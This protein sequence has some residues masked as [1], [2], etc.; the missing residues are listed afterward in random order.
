MVRLREYETA[1]LSLSSYVV[2]R[3]GALFI[4]L[5]VSPSRMSRHGGT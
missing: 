5:S 1:E 2:A 4:A 3:S